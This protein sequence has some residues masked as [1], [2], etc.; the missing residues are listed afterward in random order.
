MSSSSNWGF[1]SRDKTITSTG[2][3]G[4]SAPD[5]L[6]ALLDEVRG[7]IPFIPGSSLKFDFYLG[8]GG[9]FEVNREVY[10]ESENPDSKAFF[11]AVKHVKSQNAQANRSAVL[12]SSIRRE[13]QVLTQANLE[14]VPNILGLLGY[15]MTECQDGVS[16]YLVTEYSENGTLSDFLKATH[17]RPQARRGL[18]LDIATGLKALHDSGIIHGDIKLANTLV[19][20]NARVQ[21]DRKWTAKLAD[22]GAAIFGNESHDSVY[23]GTILYNAPEQRDRHLVS[24]FQSRV[25]P[26]PRSFSFPRPCLTVTQR[27]EN[28]ND[29]P[30]IC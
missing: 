1:I 28:G 18:A 4:A 16:L 27:S 17:L 20:P 12:Y 25:S 9:S 14:H 29:N 21:E 13:I 22:M 11:V 10:N 6:T 19:F 7:K 23:T 3:P 8:R 2:Q 26:L 24:R 15:G 30:F 5:N